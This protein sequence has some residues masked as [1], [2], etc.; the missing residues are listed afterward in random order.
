MKRCIRMLGLGGLAV[1]LVG[2]ASVNVRSERDKGAAA[3][4]GQG[5]VTGFLNKTLENC[6]AMARYVVYVPHDYTP[7]KAWPLIVFL[8]G[9]GERGS[10]GLIQTEVGI[11]TAIRR[12]ADWFP[13]IVLFPQ[14]PESKFWDVIIG[15]IERAMTKTQQEYRIDPDRIYLTGLSMGGYGVW[16]WGAKKTDTFAA[17]MP[18]CGGG[19]MSELLLMSRKPPVYDFGSMEE[20]VKK[21]SKVP[22][23]AFHGADDE[24][25]PPDRSRRMVKLVK[26]A[27]GDVKYTEF[28][29]TGHNSW[30][31]AYGEEKH[32]LWLLKQKKR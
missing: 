6:D 32:I 7:D 16:L 1:A 11:G 13:A 3:Q 27:G 17:L 8:H 28:P 24:T 25:V 18:I 19:D 20:R 4:G 22:I 9:A 12:H 26:D 30:D 21:L 5:M 31:A 2:C 23:W 10:D 15:D 29:K 14:C